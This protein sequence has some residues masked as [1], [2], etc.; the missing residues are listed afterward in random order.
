MEHRYRESQQSIRRSNRSD[1][2]TAIACVLLWQQ[3]REQVERLSQPQV[4]LGDPCR[5]LQGLV[6][7]TRSLLR[8]AHLLHARSEQY[9]GF[10]ADP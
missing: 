3:Q 7:S 8:Q 5:N 4:H 6:Q 1:T 9:R 10:V 2:D